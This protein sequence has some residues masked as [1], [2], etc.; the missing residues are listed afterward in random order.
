MR[1]RLLPLL[2]LLVSVLG[3]V[4][5]LTAQRGFRAPPSRVEIGD[6]P[7]ERSGF[8]FCRLAYTSMRQEQGGSGWNTDFPA[9]DENLMFRLSELTLTEIT[10]FDD[11]SP[12]HG[13][14][15][16]NDPQIYQCPFLFASDIGTVEFNDEEVVMLRDYLLKGGFLWV[17]DFWGDY[18][19]RMWVAEIQ[20]VIPEYSIQEITPQHE[21]FSSFYF[22]DE[23]PQIP[24][25]QHWRRT[26]GTTSERGQ[27]TAV[28]HIYSISDE[29]G[30]IMVLM[31]HNTDIADA[32]E[33]EGEDFQFFNL[34]SPRGY[35]VGINIAIWSMTH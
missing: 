27:E 15:R 7:E 18:A 14:V 17:D 3:A 21:L 13:L 1:N 20:R 30:R 19:W 25:I 24:N 32:W 8:T 33:R 6:I 16:A 31:T 29:E 26:G 11:G 5:A 4:G 23:L 28:P 9:A 10:T 34:F 2:I 35:S 12:R 22:V